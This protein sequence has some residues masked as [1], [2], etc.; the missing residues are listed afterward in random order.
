MLVGGMR[1]VRGAQ[2][3]A[4]R[5]T[6]DLLF[7]GALLA[8]NPQTPFVHRRIREVLDEWKRATDAPDG[9]MFYQLIEQARA[10]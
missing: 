1:S 7:V 5:S 3:I 9:S 6:L 2:A 10:Y 8:L 4:L